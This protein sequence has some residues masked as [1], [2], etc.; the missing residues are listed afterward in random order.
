VGLIS[1]S[2]Y[3]WHWPLIIF[4]SQW[5]FGTLAPM[6]MTAVIG[7]SVI[8]AVASWKFVEAPF[9]RRGGVLTR[10]QLFVAA[11][12][13][14]ACLAA[15]GAWGGLTDGWPQR[16]P[17]DVAQIAAYSSSVTTR[18]YEC[19]DRP[20]FR[21]PVEQACSYGGDVPPSYAVW[22]D[23]HADAMIDAIGKRAAAHNSSVRFFG[24]SGCPPIIGMERED[25]ENPCAARN[26]QTL[27]EI[28]RD[29][30]LTTVILIA[31]YAVY[32]AGYTGDF[33]P[34]EAQ[35]Q[36]N[37]YLS[38]ESR[39]RLSSDERNALF[40]RQTATTVSRL[41][42]A[43]KKVV[44]VYPVPEVGYDV[45]LTLARMARDRRDVTSFT[46]PFSYFQQRQAPVFDALDRAGDSSLIVRIYPHRLLCDG[47]R[48]IVYAGGKPLYRDDDHLSPAGAD[49]VAPLFEPLFTSD[50][51]AAAAAGV[52][53][54]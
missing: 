7:V 35:V 33:G 18:H 3:L 17:F 30:G 41:L 32:L 47:V 26:Q 1:Y 16:F 37:A 6:E 43:G 19:F 12:A 36:L 45:P 50:P 22:G 9:R 51:D 2:L 44:L 31:R 23:S 20:D 52:R 42:S 49:F 38:D 21:V 13:V 40:V 46:R 29:A 10:R 28:L 15:F 11:A 53:A 24:S 34:A 5:E 48:C 4:A 27:D 8:A 39:A 25:L 14:S 54:R